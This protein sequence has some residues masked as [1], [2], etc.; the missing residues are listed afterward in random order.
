VDQEGRES[1]PAKRNFQREVLAPLTVQVEGEGTVTASFLGTT[2]RVLEKGYTIVA[3]PRPGF[4]FREWQGEFGFDPRL[5]FTMS[6]GLVLTA[7]FIPNPYPE[8]VGTYAALLEGEAPDHRTRGSINLKLTASGAFTGKL[9]FG[10]LVHRLRGNFDAAGGAYISAK[11]GKRRFLNASLTMNFET[12]N[13]EVT[14]GF[15]ED[16]NYFEGR[17]TAIRA[18]YDV[19][20][21]PC[22][23]A[24]TYDLVLRTS[25]EE[26]APALAGQPG[27]LTIAP[28]GKATLQGT[29]GDGTSWKTS[30]YLRVDGNLPVYVRLTGGEGSLSG[31]LLFT[32][33]PQPAA[34]GQLFLS[35]P[36]ASGGEP[37]TETLEAAVSPRVG[38]P[39]AEP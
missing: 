35:T 17:G 27:T 34:S 10:G 30:G 32:A 5:R 8:L 7:V 33:D 11:S 16:E 13:I 23:F 37:L 21:A 19:D 1:A 38:S 4:I 15:S 14:A 24:G 18:D 22:A 25:G 12:R 6:E 39:A 3:Q 36:S 26:S 20:D 29:L 2:Q 28:D 31:N 9:M